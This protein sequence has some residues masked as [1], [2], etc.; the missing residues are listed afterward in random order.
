MSNSLHLKKT[1]HIFYSTLKEKCQIYACVDCLK[2]ALVFNCVDSAI[3]CK[4][5][6]REM[7]LFTTPTLWKKKD[8]HDRVMHRYFLVL[9]ASVHILL[10]YLDFSVTGS[11]I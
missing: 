7:P 5:T 10:I 9:E 4:G 1:K 2:Q 3:L 8:N 11:V 6:P